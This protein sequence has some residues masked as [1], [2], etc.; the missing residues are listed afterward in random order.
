M[1]R[2][3]FQQERDPASDAALKEE[4]DRECGSDVECHEDCTF[5][6]ENECDEWILIV[7]FNILLVLFK[8]TWIM[9]EFEWVWA[10]SRWQLKYFDLHFFSLGLSFVLHIIMKI[11]IFVFTWKKQNEHALICIQRMWENIRTLTQDWHIPNL[12]LN[13]ST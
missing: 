9:N 6:A 8:F 5:C 3:D 11:N 4:C 12:I 13:R 7:Y 10:M 1:E 2:A